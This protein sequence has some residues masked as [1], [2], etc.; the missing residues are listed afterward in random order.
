MKIDFQNIIYIF[1]IIIWVVI[2]FI[3]KNKKKE[4]QPSPS[5]PPPTGE[6][7]QQPDITTILEEILG[8]KTEKEK[9]VTVPAEKQQTKKFSP[10]VSPNTTYPG[11]E[12]T[13]KV[14]KKK[15][16]PAPKQIIAKEDISGPEFSYHTGHETGNENSSLTGAPG[17][18]TIMEETP[19]DLRKAVIFS[20]ILNPPFQ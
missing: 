15:F 1:A 6:T 17:L 13:E 18:A 10:F 16:S 12:K 3:R 20:E 7:N 9:P 4:G 14:P 5:T 2:G 11:K 19:F 8:K